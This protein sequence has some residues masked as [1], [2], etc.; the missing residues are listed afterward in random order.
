MADPSKNRTIYRFATFEI[1]SEAGEMRKSGMR[2]FRSS[3]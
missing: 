3:P 2:V 1:D